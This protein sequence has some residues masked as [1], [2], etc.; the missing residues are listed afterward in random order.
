MYVSRDSF[1]TLSSLKRKL[2]DRIGA[3]EAVGDTADAKL[4]LERCAKLAVG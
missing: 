3:T 1:T 2:V 4:I